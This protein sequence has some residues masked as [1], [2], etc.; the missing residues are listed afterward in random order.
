MLDIKIEAMI[1]ELIQ[2]SPEHL[3]YEKGLRKMEIQ[4][5]E[6]QIMNIEIAKIVVKQK[7]EILKLLKIKEWAEKYKEEIENQ[8]LRDELFEIVMG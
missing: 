2:L 8:Q 4:A 7:E 3:N 6:S 1:V 5:L